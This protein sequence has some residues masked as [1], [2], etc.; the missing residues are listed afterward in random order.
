MTSPPRYKN[1]IE[2]S[3]RSLSPE[4]HRRFQNRIEPPQLSQPVKKQTTSVNVKKNYI[5]GTMMEENEVLVKLL[6]ISNFT[7]KD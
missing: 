6:Q 4:I 1:R 5:E 3:K 2:D 7:K